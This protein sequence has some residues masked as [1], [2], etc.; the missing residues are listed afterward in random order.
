MKKVLITREIG[1]F[2]EIKDMFLSYNLQPIPFPVISFSP[3]EFE[4]DE[5]RFDY[6]VFTSSNGV[7]FFLDRYKPTK[8]KI[9]AVGKKTAEVLKERGYTDLIIPREYSSEGVLDYISQHQEDF[10][11]SR[12]GLV[13]A[14][15]G[16]DTLITK[17]PEYVQ[18]ELIKVYRTDYSIPENKDEIRHL[19]ERAEID[20]VVF[21]SPSTVEG[22][23]NVFPDGV[24]LLE[25]VKVAVIGK[26]TKTATQSK[27]IKVDLVPSK[28]TFEDLAVQLSRYI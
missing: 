10:A 6:L 18:V 14:V 13:R 20:F 2:N 7:K 19:L 8:P 11:D 5:N 22:F 1:Q 27:G 3:V 26:T 23:L 4:F 25:K 15:E 28:Y 9:I 16:M 17:K 12:I 24:N 21:S